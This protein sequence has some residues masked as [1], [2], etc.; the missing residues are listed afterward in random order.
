[1]MIPRTLRF[2]LPDDMAD[3]ALRIR[4]PRP[5][6]PPTSLVPPESHPFMGVPFLAFRLSGWSCCCCTGLLRSMTGPCQRTFQ[7]LL[8]VTASGSAWV[9]AMLLSSEGGAFCV[10]GLHS[11]PHEPCHRLLWMLLPLAGGQSR[12]RDS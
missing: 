12:V 4:A 8:H 1:M 3:N 9:E 11:P 5:L 10:Q 7:G 6:P 2:M